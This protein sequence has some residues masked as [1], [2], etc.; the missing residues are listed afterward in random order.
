LI[1]SSE[2][3]RQTDAPESSQTIPRA[4][5]AR[6]ISLV[7]KRDSGSPLAAG[8]SQASA[9][10]S[11][12]TS[13]G[14]AGGLPRRGRSSSPV[15]PSSWKRLRHIDTT[16]RRVFSRAAI[17]SLRSPWAA[18]STICAR[19]TSRYGNVYFR[20]LA[21]KI[22]RCSW[23]NSIVYGLLLGIRTPWK[24]DKDATDGTPRPGHKT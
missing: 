15:S 3:Q 23:L 16:S 7:E 22:R 20:A 10:T 21:R 19:T 5:A 14:K 8:S 6:A 17:S 24:K 1:A 18:K 13:G 11:A 4:T 2:S 12:R 9:F